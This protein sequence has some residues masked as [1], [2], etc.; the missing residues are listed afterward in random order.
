MSPIISLHR[1]TVKKTFLRSRMV[2]GLIVLVG[3]LLIF[4]LT[5]DIRRLLKASDQIKL[6]ENQVRELEKENQQLEEKK[7]YYQSP[8]FIEEQA[9]DKL[10]MAKPGETIV[11]LPQN[12]EE[13][14]GKTKKVTPPELPNW[15]KWWKLF[16]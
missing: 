3:I 1:T 14:L 16:F 6:A 4:N 15:Q 7:E 10:N 9:R 13:V 12:L 8:E 2:Q 11:I 5:R